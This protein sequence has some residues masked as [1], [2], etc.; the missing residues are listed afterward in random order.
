MNGRKW[1]DDDIEIIDWGEDEEEE[2]IAGFTGLSKR[3]D[4]GRH[5]KEEKPEDTFSWR[6]E[7]FSCVKLVLFAVIAAFIIDH[8]FIVNAEVPSGSM[9]NT[10]MT[11]SRMIGWRLSY[12]FRNEPQR[13][14]VI[15]FK[16]PDDP[17]KNYVK[18]VIGLPGERIKVED[19][20]TYI[21]D[22]PLEEDYVVFKD[23]ED[24]IVE[25]D[26]SGDFAEVKVP[27]ESYFVMGDNRNRSKDSR[28]WTTTNFVPKD[29]ILGKALFCYWHKGPE[30]DLLA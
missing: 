22:E 20:I 3:N 13:G 19:G 6:K 1:I 4:S 18:R 21:N 8:V 17:S 27:E 24:N 15:I 2:D 14:D 11:D 9:E 29:N 26:G 12:K 30:F 16:Y 25:R 28:Y 5:K 23:M 7:I 10:I